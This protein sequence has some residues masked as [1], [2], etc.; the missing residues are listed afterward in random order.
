[1]DRENKNPL[2]TIVTPSFNQG[3]FIRETIESVLAQDYSPIEYLVMDGGSTDETLGVLKSFGDRFYWASERDKGQSQAIN[4]GWRRAQG[5]YLAWLNSDDIYL[6]G[7]VSKGVTFLQQH[8]AIGAVYG[9]GYHI[10]EN[11]RILEPYPTEPFNRQRLAETCYICQPTVFIR[12]SVLEKIGFL[13]ENLHFCMDYD[14]WFRIARDF[15]F[16][17]IPD[18][19]ACT[20]FYRTTKT[21]GQKVQVHKEIMSVVFRHHHAVPPSWVYGYGHAFLEKYLTRSR[22]HEN[23]LFIIGLIGLAI[24]NFLR[25]NHRVPYSEFRRWLEWL[26]PRWRK[27]LFR[28][29][30]RKDGLEP[31]DRK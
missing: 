6:P 21:L 13:D 8:P 9:H 1:V 17:L 7:A 15:D 25:Y 29:Q 18:F 2:V 31:E 19:L 30:S 23:F 10:E 3:R 27:T 14:L 12:K 4:K 11:G 5:V 28:N 16:G 24:G 26:R 22:P 20:R